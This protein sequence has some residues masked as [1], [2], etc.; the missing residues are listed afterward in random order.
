MQT[1]K[2]AYAKPEVEVHGSMQDLTRGAVGARKDG[3][4]GGKSKATGAA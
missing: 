1:E 2:K 4:A 3:G